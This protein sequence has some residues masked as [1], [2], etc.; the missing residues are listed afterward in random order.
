MLNFFSG[1]DLFVKLYSQFEVRGLL[2]NLLLYTTQHSTHE[3]LRSYF[4]YSKNLPSARALPK[5]T[6]VRYFEYKYWIFDGFHP[7]ILL[8]S[9]RMSYNNKW[10]QK[11]ILLFDL[12]LE[13]LH[14]TD[15][16]VPERETR[17]YDRAAVELVREAVLAN[18]PLD[19]TS[20][21]NTMLL[22]H[23]SPEPYRRLYRPKGDLGLDK[24]V[25]TMVTDGNY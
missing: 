16:D 10:T 9:L 24:I 12:L 7:R 23:R 3:F 5:K 6:L 2:N 15:N 14:L 20:I 22:L 17:E 8:K 21:G 13:Y 25:K 1:A 4:E 18:S 11:T 19:F